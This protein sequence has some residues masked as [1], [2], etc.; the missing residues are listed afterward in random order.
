MGYKKTGIIKIE[1]FKRR[2]GI[3]EKSHKTRKDHWGGNVNH[4]FLFCV[5]IT[6]QLYN[7][8]LMIRVKIGICCL[9]I[10]QSTYTHGGGAGTPLENLGCLV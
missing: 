4:K 2:I 3:A 9:T 5:P 1:N 10:T 7:G 6:F 8:P